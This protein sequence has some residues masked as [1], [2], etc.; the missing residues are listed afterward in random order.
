[1][2]ASKINVSRD[3]N[4]NLTEAKRSERSVDNQVPDAPLRKVLHVA[5]FSMFLQRLCVRARACL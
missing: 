5:C 2:S 4:G 3:M 1:M